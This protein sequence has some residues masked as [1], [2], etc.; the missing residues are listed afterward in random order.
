VGADPVTGQAPDTSVLVND[1]GIVG[2][3]ARISLFK[4]FNGLEDRFDF[5]G[6][7]FGI[8]VVVTDSG[9]EDAFSGAFRQPVPDIGALEKTFAIAFK[10]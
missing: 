5:P 7:I 6:K 8:D 9:K 3:E 1:D 10:S 4:G 2:Q